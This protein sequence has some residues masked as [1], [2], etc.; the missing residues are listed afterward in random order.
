[1]IDKVEL[2]CEFSEFGCDKY[3]RKDMMANHLKECEFDPK[4]KRICECGTEFYPSR[5]EKRHNCIIHFK[6]YISG[7]QKELYDLEIITQ[8]QE[9]S[10]EEL[11]KRISSLHIVLLFLVVAMML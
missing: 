11:E 7:Y 5:G 10:I 9:K 2:S 8:R 4:N 3:I 1:M 6:N